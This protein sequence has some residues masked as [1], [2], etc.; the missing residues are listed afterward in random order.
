MGDA[1]MAVNDET[2]EIDGASGFCGSAVAHDQTALWVA[3]EY[4]VLAVD[5]YGGGS[6]YGMATFDSRIKDLTFSGARIYV[7][8][9]DGTIRFYQVY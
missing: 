1:I 9:E 7:L 8:F 3:K 6:I 5:P 2:G 4:D